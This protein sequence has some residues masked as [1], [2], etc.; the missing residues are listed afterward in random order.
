MRMLLVEDTEDLAIAIAESFARRG[1]AV[2]CA[3]T[4]AD[5]L[6]ALRVQDYDIAILDIQLP[7]GE[8]TTLLRTLRQEGHSL[9]IL[10]LT[11]RG[12]VEM[13]IKTLD[14]GADD[15]MVKPFELGELHARVRALARRGHSVR[16]VIQTYG[17]LRFDAARRELTAAG[18]PIA[19]TRRE[20]SL[21][22]VLLSNAGRVV[23][24][25]HIYERMFS[26]NDEDVGMNTVETYVARLR[27]KICKSQVSI[28]TLRGLGYQ[29]TTHEQ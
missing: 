25:E 10:M 16:E 14:Q 29:M 8:G 21:L 6:A 23:T 4:L 12:E 5:A 26:F 7:D 17:D 20:Y 3:G 9:P 2:D 22:E 19:L 1:D 13:R 18:A 15:Y 27:R 11:A 28:R 24:K